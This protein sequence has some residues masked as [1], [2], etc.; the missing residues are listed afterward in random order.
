MSQSK[1]LIREIG[2][3][4]VNY[5]INNNNARISNLGTPVN[6]NDAATKQYVDNNITSSGLNPGSGIVISSGNTISVSSSLTHVTAIGNINTGTWSA[7]TI[8]VVYGGTGKSSFTPNKFVIGNGTSPLI[9]LDSVSFES[10]SLKS[11]SPVIFADTSN[12]LGIGSG[13]SLTILGGTSISKSLIV[14]Q[15]TTVNNNL[16]VLGDTTVGNITISGT[17]SFTQVSSTN[18]SFTNATT[19]NSYISNLTAA[20]TVVTTNSTANLYTTNASVSNMVVT[21]LLSPNGTVSNLNCLSATVNSSVFSNLTSASIYGTN[22]FFVNELVSSSTITNLRLTSCTGTNILLTTLVCPT[23]TSTNVNNNGS[24][25]TGNLVV[26]TNTVLS[27]ATT[28][29]LTLSQGT[30]GNCI[31]TGIT[32]STHL[33]SN[34][35]VTNITNTNLLTTNT[36][37]TNLTASNVA[38]T[39]LTTSQLLTTNVTTSNM[40]ATGIS[41]M[42]TVQTTNLSTGQ[43]F[44]SNNTRTL[45][46]FTSNLTSASN[47]LSFI[48]N[49]SMTNTNFLGSNITSNNLVNNN[50]AILGTVQSSQ[51]STGNLFVSS[52]SNLNQLIV[53]NISTNSLRI[54]DLTIAST[55]NTNSVSSATLFVSGLVQSRNFLGTA[56]TVTTLNSSNISTGTLNVSGLGVFTTVNSVSVSS[57]NIFVS[58]LTQST[59]IQSTN[60]S[61]NNLNVVS[62][63]FGN[64][65]VDNNCVIK[66]SISLGSNFSGTPYSTSGTV[67]SVLPLLFTDTY[68]STGTTNTMWSLNYLSAPTLAAQNSG[69][70]TNKASTLHVGNKPSPGAN[71]TINYS[72]ALSIGYVANQSGNYLTG[73]IMFERNDGNWYNSIYTEDATNRFVLANGSLA[74]GAGIGLYTYTDTPIVFSHIPSSTNVTPTQFARFT[75]TTSTFASTQESINGSSGSVVVSGGLGVSKTLCCNCLALSNVFLTV[76]TNNSNVTIPESCSVA[77]LKPSTSLANLTINFPTSPANGQILCITTIQNITNTSFGNT[78][79]SPANLTSNSPL[80]F[81][82]S[83]SDSTWYPI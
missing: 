49:T 18:S 37:V 2:G 58:G 29:N 1:N 78:N 64:V 73:Q 70:T 48:Q 5:Y 8:S 23:I 7:N 69:I 75:R 47:I 83:L 12:S 55:V 25:T 28:T 13:G 38:T 4:E 45:N 61:V 32:S 59:N 15:N 6:P 31:F 57:G 39:N 82:Y 81:V 67:L 33:C 24:L 34:E 76:P 3:L 36:V 51:V 22:N 46:L 41:I 80:R 71:Q 62:S 16:L 9:A 26:R 63:T 65:N 54:S 27:N 40:N 14:G 17:S 21:N 20:S 43:L 11:T 19:N 66:K 53:N 60:N 72:G 50:I 44:V 79:L 77:I 35:T 56:C 30:V 10:N 42:G 74:G 68:S 52:S